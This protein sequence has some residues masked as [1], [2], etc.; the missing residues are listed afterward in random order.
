MHLI[1]VYEYDLRDKL[2]ELKSSFDY[3]DPDRVDII[4]SCIEEMIEIERLLANIRGG[5]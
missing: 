1:E 3:I 4:D 2:E 5:M